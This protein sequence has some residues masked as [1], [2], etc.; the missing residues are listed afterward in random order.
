[1]NLAG[2]ISKIIDV[3][4]HPRWDA[5]TKLRHVARACG[6][7]DLEAQNWTKVAEPDPKDWVRFDTMEELRKNQRARERYRR[8]AQTGKCVSC[9]K[10][11]DLKT[12]V[13]SSCKERR[14]FQ[15]AK[16]GG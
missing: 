16:R 1:M 10:P 8:Y 13:C 6:L 2:T 7:P 5:P 11:N 3:L 15:L 14:K 9:G 12:L 4:Q